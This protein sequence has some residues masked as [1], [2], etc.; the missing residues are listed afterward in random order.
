VTSI[1]IQNVDAHVQQVRRRPARSIRLAVKIGSQLCLR[2]LDVLPQSF[3]PTSRVDIA[4]NEAHD[5]QSAALFFGA[6]PAS[7][8]FK[9]APNFWVPLTPRAANRARRAQVLRSVIRPPSMALRLH[10]VRLTQMTW[11][12]AGCVYGFISE[13]IAARILLE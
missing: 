2:S 4:L 11:Q 5:P 10:S 3:E 1:R 12:A 9:N 6:S 8:S 13:S 7:F